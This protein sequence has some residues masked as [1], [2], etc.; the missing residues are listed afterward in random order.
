MEPPRRRWPTRVV[1]PRPLRSPA[2]VTYVFHWVGTKPS[3][4]CTMS[5]MGRSRQVTPELTARQREV[6]DL[7]ARGHTNREIAEVLGISVNGAKWHV[8][9]LL[10]KFA[11]DGR[12][13]LA[14][15]WT[16]DRNLWTRTGRWLATFGG[17]SLSKGAAVVATVAVMAAAALG[18]VVIFSGA[19]DADKGA[20]PSQPAP[21]TTP[22]SGTTPSVPT[23]T[24]LPPLTQP[25]LGAIGDAN[26]L[27][28]W[29][30]P[31]ADLT[32][33]IG[34]LNGDLGGYI[35]LVDPA[36]GLVLGKV[37]V[38]YAP[39]AVFRRPAGELLIAHQP[40]GPPKT[41]GGR[42]WIGEPTLVVLDLATLR[43]K[44]EIPLPQRSFF[45]TYFAGMKL[46]DD[47]RY[48]FYAAVYQPQG[49]CS[50]E[51]E[52][53]RPAGTEGHCDHPFVGTIDFD[54]ATPVAAL[55]EV[56][57]VNCSNG[58]PR[59]VDGH[60]GYILCVNGTTFALDAANPAA[61]VKV[62]DATSRPNETDPVLS[63]NL[64]N[65]VSIVREPGGASGI[66]YSSGQF[67]LQPSVGS[68]QRLSALPSGASLGLNPPTVLGD[69]IYLSY[70]DDYSS[71]TMSGLA[72]FDWQRGVIER[73]VPFEPA[74]S[75]YL[76]D[77]RT[78]LILLKDG[79]LQRINLQTGQRVVLGGR[80][81]LLQMQADFLP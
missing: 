49:G 80:L 48:L 58:P 40:L 27:K 2:A 1:W 6:L 66:L 78:V 55:V 5:V 60:T 9:E 26:G 74:I 7:L 43:V 32:L 14:E 76:V 25:V 4:R 72:V 8:G 18:A 35:L 42:D 3:P 19:E 11:V 34:V 68:E 56:P 45:T 38:G 16:R 46:T 12:E 17:L 61:I 20:S 70:R 37:E 39:W 62:S 51:D 31:G 54:A 69:R 67:L 28:M 24:V 22:G 50:A 52:R 63:H 64:T 71:Q 75:V 81:A 29:A 41:D 21:S 33:T 65:V 15:C 57:L 23:A 30:V 13:E 47:G 53:T 36:T 10:T 59:L 79:S 77:E 44:R 73:D